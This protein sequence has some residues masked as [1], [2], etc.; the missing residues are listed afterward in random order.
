VHARDLFDLSGKVAVVTGGGVGIGASMAE[1]LA[2]L[3]AD[4]AVCSRKLER[5]QET[6]E[7]LVAIGVKAHAFRCDISDAEQVRTTVGQ[8]IRAFGKVDI[9]V[10]NAGTLRAGAF[11]NSHSSEW[12]HVLNTNVRGVFACTQAFGV[13]MIE[14]EAGKVI[15]IASVA[16]LVGAPS[17]YMDATT[18]NA[19]KG[20]V[21]T[22]TRDLACKWASHGIQ[23]NAIAP[24]W[25]PSHLTRQTLET[26]GE[27]ILADI[28]QRRFGGGDDLK[29]AVGYLASN[30][31][32]YVT[33]QVL[34]V[35]GGLTA[36]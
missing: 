2:E 30:A 28:P 34:V 11:E 7:K 25:F 29:G 26:H 27:L 16:G 13:P 1:G 12:D 24:G 5:C 19:S 22:F 14:Q 18:Y 31:A 4:V 35:D 8:V 32:D 6:A 36:W 15:N 9:L 10:N 33:G 21:I 3:G 17:D 23:V 20:A